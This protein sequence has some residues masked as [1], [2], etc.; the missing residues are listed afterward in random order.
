MSKK[1][2][3]ETDLPIKWL[4]DEQVFYVDMDAIG[5]VN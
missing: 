4:K 1:I 5:G 2:N 3:R